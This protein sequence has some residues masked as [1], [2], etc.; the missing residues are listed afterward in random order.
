MSRYSR[1]IALFA[2]LALSL[3][4]SAVATA[5]VHHGHKGHHHARRHAGHARK[6]GARSTVASE[7]P[8]AG[9]NGSGQP[10]SASD[11]AAQAAACSK[12][13]TTS[14]NVQY[15]DQTGACSADTGQGGSDSQN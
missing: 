1:L 5:S 4:G 12:S 13:G 10:E 2:V 14:S 9:E 11:E 7:S 15:D 6:A 8:A 3:S